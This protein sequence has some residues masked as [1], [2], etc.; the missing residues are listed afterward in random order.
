MFTQFPQ[1]LPQ[2]VTAGVCTAK[3]T[4]EPARNLFRLQAKRVAWWAVAPTPPPSRAF[5]QHFDLTSA[6]HRR[7]AID[8]Q[9]QAGATRG[10]QTAVYSLRGR[11]ETRHKRSSSRISS[12]SMSAE[13]AAAAPSS[14]VA[15]AAARFGLAGRKCVG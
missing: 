8:R 2:P 3:G 13:A 6:S 4:D 5:L 11:Q 1:Q 10:E 9:P 14:A 15:A 12:S 7:F